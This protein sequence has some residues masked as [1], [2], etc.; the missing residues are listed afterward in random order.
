MQ[1]HVK[2]D[3]LKVLKLGFSAIKSKRY[4]QLQ[5]ISNRIIHSMTIYQDKDVVDIAILIYSLDKI[6]E[7][8]KV[9]EYKGVEEFKRKVLNRISNC[10]TALKKNDFKAYSKSVANLISAISSFTKKFKFYVEDVLRFAKVK[11]G[12]MMYEHGVSL[13]TA[14]KATGASKWELMEAH[15]ERYSKSWE[16]ISIESRLKIL[17]SL[18]GK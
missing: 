3:V 8:E 18:F 16:P 6:L 17:R 14:A 2:Q 1:G 13:G 5:D 9:E 15:G 10:I 11:K 4:T 12:T 7:T